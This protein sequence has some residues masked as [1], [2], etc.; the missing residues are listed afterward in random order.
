MTSPDRTPEPLDPVAT[1]PTGPMP[2]TRARAR[3]AVPAVA[4]VAVGAAFT[5]PAIA[6]A[7]SPDL[8]DVT[9][10]QLLASVASAEPTPLSGTAVYTARLGLPEVSTELTGGADPLN[11]LSGS[12]TIR[13]WSDGS[14]RSRVSLLGAT[15]EYSVVTDGTQVW[16][17][18]S[19]KD[20]V[21]HVSLDDQLSGMLTVL[22]QQQA[23]KASSADVPTPDEL[24]TQILDHARE[25][26]DITVTDPVTVAGRSAYEVRIVPTTT[27]TL[28]DEVLIAVDGETSVPLSVQVFSTQDPDSPALELAFTD[29]SFTT[30]SDEALAFSAPAGATVNEK[31]LTLADLDPDGTL[32]GALTGATD[33]ALDGGAWADQHADASGTPTLPEGVSVTGEGWATVVQR[34]GVDVAGLLSGDPAAVAELAGEDSPFGDSANGDL[35]GEFAG[36]GDG[37][38][39]SLDTSALYDQ[40]TTPVDGGRVLSSA[41]LSVLVTD[42]GRVLVGS[43]PTQTLLQTAGLA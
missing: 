3:W 22:E 16:T 8:P 30:P 40:L 29:V 33:G 26:S 14:D 9:A 27:G 1:S 17:Y 11:L 35:F 42:D 5:I 31:V 13:V 38:G 4:V 12:S 34:D 20:E 36:D 19:G 21:R 24:A 6:S 39:L 7:D 28:V 15:S 10:E 2:R 37:P 43:V 23:A 18:S 25:D 32:T 41:L